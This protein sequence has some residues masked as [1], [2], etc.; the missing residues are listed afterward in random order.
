[1]CVQCVGLCSYCDCR[2]LPVISRLS[3]E[4]ASIL[5]VADTLRALLSTP[6]PDNG[7][8][9]EGHDAHTLLS[10]L[11]T[12][13]MEHGSY[14]ERSLYHELRDDSTFASA[15]RSLC[16]EHL[17]I[18]RSLQR[19]VD[20]A[21]PTAELVLPMLN[22]LGRHIMKEERGLFPPA[23]ILLGTAAWERAA[24]QS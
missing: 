18:Q 15:A 20:S 10:R 4:H 23:V 6:A 19:A 1:M 3:C 8:A 22:Q 5:E 13:L 16:G 11:S 17:S 21:R 24:A 7:E 14:E 2:T 12:M 9:S